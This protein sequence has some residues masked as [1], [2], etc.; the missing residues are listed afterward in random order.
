MKKTEKRIIPL[1]TIL[2]P[3]I[4]KE[5]EEK[6]P[7]VSSNGIEYKQTFSFVGFPV[8]FDYNELFD[9]ASTCEIDSA[10]ALAVLLVCL[11][12]MGE[13]YGFYFVAHN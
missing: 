4:F 12:K 6:Y 1:R 5:M 10:H 9:L 11:T 7:S 8:D 13:S 2:T 3:D